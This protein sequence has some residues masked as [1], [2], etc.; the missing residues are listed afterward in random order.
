MFQST[1]PRRVRLFA[2]LNVLRNGQFQSTHPRRVRP[3]QKI[4]LTNFVCFNPRTHV[5]CDQ[6]MFA[7]MAEIELFQSTHPRRVRL[8]IL[9]WICSGKCFNPRTHVGCDFAIL[10]YSSLLISFN[11]RTHVGCDRILF[12]A[13]F[14]RHLEDSFRESP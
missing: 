2:T 13:L 14:F 10:I 3:M 8:I 9:L 7:P 11:P 4:F 12:L 1:H 5:G 6:D